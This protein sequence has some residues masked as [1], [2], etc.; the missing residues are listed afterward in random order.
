MPIERI[1][2]NARLMQADAVVMMRFDSLF[3]AL[4]VAQDF[5]RRVVARDA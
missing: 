3:Q 4:P 5:A 2:K 1:V